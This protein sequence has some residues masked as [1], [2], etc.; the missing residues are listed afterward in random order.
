MFNSAIN[1]AK[2]NAAAPLEPLMD[3]FAR[4]PNEENARALLITLRQLRREK[5]VSKAIEE[6]ILDDIESFLPGF[7]PASVP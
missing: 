4:R 6:G 2:R 7:D 1:A 3:A 5:K